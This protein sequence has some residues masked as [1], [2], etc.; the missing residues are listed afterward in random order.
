MKK[1]LS[2]IISCLL[3]GC[4][5]P[6]DEQVINDVKKSITD[7]AKLHFGSCQNYKFL[8]NSNVSEYKN[9]YL[10]N[11]DNNLNPDTLVFS[12]LKVYKH[13]DYIAVCGTVSGKTDISKQGAR[14]VEIWGTDVNAEM[15]SKY[16]G[17][18][19]SNMLSNPIEYYRKFQ[20]DYCK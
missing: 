5:Q 13:T 15:Q 2:I 20:R 8:S 16:S 1:C 6:S 11:C 4:G 14:F 3:I 7:K 18:K 12:D 19:I 9:A 10:Y 17:R